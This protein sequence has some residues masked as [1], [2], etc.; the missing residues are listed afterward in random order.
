MSSLQNLGLGSWPR[1][2]AVLSPD[3]VAVEF[4]GTVLTFAQFAA[5]VELLSAW[6]AHHGVGP[7][8]RV[9]YWGGNHVALLETLFASTRI[10]AICV[11]VNARLAPA[12]AQYILQDSGASVLFFGR[13]QSE[14]TEMIAERIPAAVLVDVDGTWVGAAY[15]HLPA[16]VA[17]VPEINCGLDDPALLMY[18]SGTTGRPKGAVLTHGNIFFN[19]VNVLIEDD[20]RPDEVCLAAAPQLDG[21]TGV[22]HDGVRLLAYILSIES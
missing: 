15:P 7:G 11:L 8:D 21:G 14:A 13:E 12:E 3:R 5:R 1:R 6:L 18:T 4:E 10:G 19:D 20:I 9:A 22:Y 2:R 16:D 17:P